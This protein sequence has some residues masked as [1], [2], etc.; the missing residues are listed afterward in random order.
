VTPEELRVKNRAYYLAHTERVRADSR[1]WRLA[2]PDK[3]RAMQKAWR[4]DHPELVRQNNRAYR[5]AHLEKLRAYGLAWRLAHPEHPREWRHA[6]P[7][8]VS[9]HDAK[10]RARK[11]DAFVERVDRM[12]VFQQHKGICGI[13]RRKITARQKWHVDHVFPL[14]R[15]GTHTYDNAQPAHDKCNLSKGAKIPKGQPTLFQVKAS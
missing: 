2:H 5:L 7:A 3:Y 8:Q 9:A 11:R 14:A 6:H 12:R 1:A 4:K 15:G 13:C 10:K